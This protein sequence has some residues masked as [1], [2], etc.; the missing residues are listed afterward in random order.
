MF[1]DNNNDVKRTLEDTDGNIMS[2]KKMKK[3]RRILR[4]PARSDVDL[5]S[6]RTGDI[7]VNEN[8]PNPLV[9][10]F[11]NYTFIIYIYGHIVSV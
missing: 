9:R 2:R 7:C 8:C 1:K 6:S 11:F 10:Y 3:M 4:R 5:K